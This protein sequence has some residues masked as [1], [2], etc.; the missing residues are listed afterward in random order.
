MKIVFG[1]RINY[2]R[3][4]ENMNFNKV[5]RNVKSIFAQI[6]HFWNKHFKEFLFTE[7]TFSKFGW[8]EIEKG[9][10]GDAL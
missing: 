7:I 4:P 1:H 6:M 10:G 8:R 2:I 5:K 9:G 3:N